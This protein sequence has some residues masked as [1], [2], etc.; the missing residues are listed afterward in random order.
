MSSTLSYLGESG[1]L[2]SAIELFSTLRFSV[3][4]TRRKCIVNCSTANGTVQAILERGSFSI[5]S[6]KSKELLEKRWRDP[7]DQSLLDVQARRKV[8]MT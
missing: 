5:S 1:K 6:E 7:R 2:L 8:T 4:E 3:N